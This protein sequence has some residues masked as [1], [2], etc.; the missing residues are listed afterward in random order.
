MEWNARD[1]GVRWKMK[2]RRGR[3]VTIMKAEELYRHCPGIRRCYNTPRRHW[4]IGVIYGNH[5]TF[6]TDSF[7]DFYAGINLIYAAFWMASYG[8]KALFEFIV[9]IYIHTPEASKSKDHIFMTNRRHC[10]QNRQ[11]NQ[12]SKREKRKGV[13]EDPSNQ[14][15]LHFLGR[16]QGPSLLFS[17][18]VSC[19]PCP[20]DAGWVVSF[21]AGC[22]AGSG[23]DSSLPCS[24]AKLT[25]ETC[26]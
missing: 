25:L 20:L 21:L 8:I 1:E 24:Q 19:A 5:V 2:R 10:K 18:G 22:D 3:A 13:S 9:I 4:E 15:M 11:T 17:F 23:L 26:S 14:R 16:P 6:N 12:D 7:L